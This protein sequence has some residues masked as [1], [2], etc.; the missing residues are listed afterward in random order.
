[1]AP[2]GFLD[3]FEFLCAHDGLLDLAHGP[4]LLI[5]ELFDAVLHQSRLEVDLLVLQGSQEHICTEI[6]LGDAVEG[7]CQDR[8]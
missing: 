3:L 8:N 5:L 2:L 4:L 1:V 6:T 7:P